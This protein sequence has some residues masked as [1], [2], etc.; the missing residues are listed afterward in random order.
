[1][2]I[3]IIIK[4]NGKFP[5]TEIGRNKNMQRLGIRCTKQEEPDSPC[6]YCDMPCNGS[7]Q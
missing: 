4:K 7:T 1:M 6:S 5:E 2:A 3:S